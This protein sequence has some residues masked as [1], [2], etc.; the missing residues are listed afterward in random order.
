[1]WILY[2]KQCGDGNHGKQCDG[3][4][5]A[6]L[7]EGDG[8]VKRK[9][10]VLCALLLCF[11]VFLSSCAE[12]QRTKYVIPT[13][14]ESVAD[15]TVAQNGK[16]SLDW[17]DAKKCVL[18]RA[19]KSGVVWSTTPYEYYKKGGDNYNLCSPLN[20]EYYNS[21]DGSINTSNASDCIDMGLVSAKK[22]DQGIRVSYYFNE[23]EI[24]VSVVY[25]LRNDS[26]L[27]TLNTADISESGLNQ[28][29]NVSVTP[30]LCSA[31]NS[32]SRSDYLFIPSGCGALMYTDTEPGDLP[33]SFSGE[34]YGND[35]V[36]TQLAVSGKE[37][38][39][40]LPVFGVRSQ[41]NA[42]CAIIENGEGAATIN[43]VA[44]NSRNDYSTVYATFNVRGYNNAELGTSSTVI[45]S[46]KRPKNKEFAVGYYPLEGKNA[47]YSGMAACYRSYLQRTGGLQQ[48]QQAQSP[49]HVTL[50]GGAQVKA[51]TLGFPHT[52]L[53]PLTTFEQ[54]QAILKDLKET[55]GQTPEVLLEGFGKSGLNIKQLAGG[56]AFS[57]TLGGKN[58][59]Q[60]LESYCRSRNIPLYTDF[61]LIHFSQSGNGF[62]VFRNPALTANLQSAVQY[63]L[64]RNVLTEDKD[65]SRVLLL[66]RSKLGQAA[67]KLAHFCQ[68]RVSGIG[69]SALGKT[70]YSDYT[71]ESTMLKGD[72]SKQMRTILGV[73]KAGDHPVTLSA[74]NAYLAGLAASLTDVP[75]QNG[76]YDALDE[77][78]PFYEMVYRG[79]I[80][81]Y[82]TAVNLS[83]DTQKQL[84]RA[85]EAGVSPSFLLSQSYDAELSTTEISLSSGIVYE[86]NK[87]LIK[88]T[89]NQVG[90]FLNR[91]AGA[92]IRSH[93][94]VQEGVSLT[95][96]DNGVSVTVNHTNKTVKVGEKE[97]PA[98]SF[99]TDG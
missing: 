83:P 31:K 21:E 3:T 57:G 75:L 87:E 34:V 25:T 97:I 8:Y 65:S 30:Y 11:S 89:V 4:P 81:L 61:D 38:P 76:G 32:D 93:A 14:M 67:E 66:Q 17:D 53:L 88:N 19:I 27:V 13:S 55:I 72:L 91:I 5:V 95:V 44:G 56:F 28:L 73:V 40:R 33:R 23:A 1:M 99:S 7:T 77:T 12:E 48:S 70:A 85:V 94:I 24:T 41:G 92:G 86:N 49:Y 9:A 82:S 43:A 46:N 22:T 51:N 50:V 15:G 26:L 62:S 98:M 84:L 16:Y 59:Q 68:N 52:E 45:L 71:E 35:P 6:G 69:L 78:I 90:N 58:R 20:I 96:F 42:M 54:A 29:L 39:I 10:S 63:T 37:E 80:P 18:L 74:A 79:S 36:R 2:W 47:D 60:E 64:K